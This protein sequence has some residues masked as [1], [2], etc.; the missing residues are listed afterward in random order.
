MPDEESGFAPLFQFARCLRYDWLTPSFSILFTYFLL[1]TATHI[2]NQNST[3]GTRNQKKHHDPCNKKKT[4]N[5]ETNICFWIFSFFA[6]QVSTGV[7]LVAL[8]ESQTISESEIEIATL[9]PCKAKLS[10]RV[11]INVPTSQ[12][13][14]NKMASLRILLAKGG[15]RAAAVATR[16]KDL[17]VSKLQFYSFYTPRNQVLDVKIW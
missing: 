12:P 6:L 1:L 4:L 13:R 17:V 3:A 16:L 2:P 8:F 15:W 5:F 10:F 9:A 11:R 7:G 14:P